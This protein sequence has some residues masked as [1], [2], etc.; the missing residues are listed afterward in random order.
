MDKDSIGYKTL[1]SR[2]VTLRATLAGLS[3]QIRNGGYLNSRAANA[4]ANPNE[5]YYVSKEYADRAGI[6][7][8]NSF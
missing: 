7:T 4:Q 8:T 1:Q 2:E 6:N 3:Q 5:N